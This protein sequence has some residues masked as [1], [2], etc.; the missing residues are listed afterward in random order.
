[1]LKTDQAATPNKILLRMPS[2]IN[3]LQSADASFSN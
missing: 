1:M 3:W 2:L